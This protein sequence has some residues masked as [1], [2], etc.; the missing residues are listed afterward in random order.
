MWAEEGISG[1]IRGDLGGLCCGMHSAHLEGPQQKYGKELWGVAIGKIRSPLPPEGGPT[2]A[3][4]CTTM[5]LYTLMKKAVRSARVSG[6]RSTTCSSP[7][8]STY[9]ANSALP[10]CSGAS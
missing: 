2:A 10:R 4:M 1:W 3:V 5:A 7:V 8:A 9:A 6:C